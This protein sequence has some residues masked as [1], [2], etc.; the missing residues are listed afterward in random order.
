MAYWSPIPIK[1]LTIPSCP[2]LLKGKSYFFMA[3]IFP[4]GADWQKKRF[5]SSQETVRG[6]YSNSSPTTEPDT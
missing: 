1:K 2:P 4:I 5:W 3:I 6:R